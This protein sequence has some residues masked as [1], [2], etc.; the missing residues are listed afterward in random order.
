MLK[1]L[2]ERWEKAFDEIELV[3]KYRNSAKTY[4]YT[5]DACF[6]LNNY[7]KE[8]FNSERPLADTASDN[9][10]PYYEYGFNSSGR[11]CYSS[12]PYNGT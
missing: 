7:T 6:Y 10:V 11:P 9:S 5:T 2:M 4:K 3:S 8:N 12:F 1:Q